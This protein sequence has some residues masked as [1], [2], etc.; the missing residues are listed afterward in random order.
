[1]SRPGHPLNR[2]PLSS[3]SVPADTKPPP[4]P[5]ARPTD[6]RELLVQTMTA[7][8]RIGRREAELFRPGAELAMPGAVWP[9]LATRRVVAVNRGAKG[10]PTPAPVHAPKFA[11]PATSESTGP[12]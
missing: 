3:P 7:K 12:R 4:R 8:A 6:A 10:T 9:E 5:T 11:S 1:M 2:L